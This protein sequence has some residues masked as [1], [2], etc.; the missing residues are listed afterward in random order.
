M[1]VIQENASDNLSFA[2]FSVVTTSPAVPDRKRFRSFS[3]EVPVFN[4]FLRLATTKGMEDLPKKLCGNSRTVLKYH[5]SLGNCNCFG[6]F[7]L[8]GSSSNYQS[9]CCM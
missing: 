5:L 9:I 7:K 4:G 6:G 2:T 1:K 3:S 8:M